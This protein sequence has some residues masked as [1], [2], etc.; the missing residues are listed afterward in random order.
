VKP[1]A[2]AQNEGFALDL[3]TGDTITYQGWAR[4]Q[5]DCDAQGVALTVFR[6]P[7]S[8]DPVAQDLILLSISLSISAICS[9]VDMD[10]RTSAWSAWACALAFALTSSTVAPVT[11]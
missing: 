4:V 5:F 9:G 11:T 1:E 8:G 3:S 7:E 6:N 10:L 2:L